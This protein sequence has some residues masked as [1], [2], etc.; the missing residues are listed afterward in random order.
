M[1]DFGALTAQQRTRQHRIDR[2]VF[3][4]K[5]PHAVSARRLAGA[6]GDA[7]VGRLRLAGQRHAFDQ[8]G[9]PQRL[10]QIAAETG[11]AV[12]RDPLAF[13]RLEQNHG[14]AP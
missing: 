1:H 4:Q 3:G 10:D 11:F 14:R 6:A 12:G 13:L 5:H 7:I 8:R 9:A 2:V